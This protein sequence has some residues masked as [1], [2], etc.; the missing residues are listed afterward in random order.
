MSIY[1]AVRVCTKVGL[2][3]AHPWYKRRILCVDCSAGAIRN[4][5]VTDWSSA[6]CDT[7]GWRLV[8]SQGVC[9]TDC[10]QKARANKLVWFLGMRPEHSHC[11]SMERENRSNSHIHWQCNASPCNRQGAT[12]ALENSQ[13]ASLW[14]IQRVSFF[15]LNRKSRLLTWW[16]LFFLDAE[17]WWNCVWSLW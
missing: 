4:K 17:N 6:D 5:D 9:R 10:M 3:L 14:P 8:P 16:N 2:I 1:M 7:N 13:G 11:F 15:S 12:C